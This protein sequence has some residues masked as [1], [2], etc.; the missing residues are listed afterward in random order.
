M[1]TLICGR[2]RI[3]SRLGAGAMAEVYAARHELIEQDAAVKLLLPEI[4]AKAGMT[5]RLLQEAQAAAAV[6]HPG[7]V[8]IYD[9]GHTADGRAYIVM[10]LLPGES[11]GQRLKRLGTLSV[12]AAADVTVLDLKKRRK[13]DPARFESK[14]RCTPFAGWTLKGWPVTTIVGGRVVWTDRK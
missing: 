10:E 1:D 13:V 5:R 6:K 14:G 2:F 7:I 12:D 3:V 11:L 4:S 8:D 9:V